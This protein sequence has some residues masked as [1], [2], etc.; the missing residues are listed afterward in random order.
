[1]AKLSKDEAIKLLADA[2]AWPAADALKRLPPGVDPALVADASMRVLAGRPWTFARSCGRLPVAA[3][4]G[5]TARLQT[6][7]R[8]PSF[9]HRYVALLASSISASRR[10]LRFASARSPRSFGP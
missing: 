1:M 7:A 9:E 8:E 2:R 5:M 10:R 3:I 4:R 6:A